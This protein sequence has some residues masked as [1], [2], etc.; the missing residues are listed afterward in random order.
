MEDGER[1]GPASPKTQ[2]IASLDTQPEVGACKPVL[3][4]QLEPHTA[5][6]FL[7]FF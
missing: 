6:P 5:L 3:L 1:G 2:D 7:H 4:E